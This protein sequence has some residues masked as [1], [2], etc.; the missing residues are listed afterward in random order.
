[1]EADLAG[2]GILFEIGGDIAEFEAHGAAP[3][4]GS[5]MGSMCLHSVKNKKKNKYRF[6]YNHNA[7]ELAGTK[8]LALGEAF[9]WL[10]LTGSC[11]CS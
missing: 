9:L 7:Y 10:R 5:V 2:A 6:I 4:L 1:V 3:G 11:K 8:S